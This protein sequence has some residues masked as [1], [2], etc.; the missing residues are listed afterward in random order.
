[1]EHRIEQAEVRI[2]HGDRIEGVYVVMRARD[3]KELAR[4]DVELVF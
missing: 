1:M 2:A 3:T 4:D